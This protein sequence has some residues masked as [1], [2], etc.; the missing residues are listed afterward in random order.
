MGSD[1]FEAEASGS[2]GGFKQVTFCRIDAPPDGNR[3]AINDLGA[4]TNYAPVPLP[5]RRVWC[6]VSSPRIKMGVGDL[7]M[8]T[9]SST[10][11]PW[12]EPV[13]LG[14]RV[15]SAT[16]DAAPAFAENDTAIYFGSRRP[17]EDGQDDG[18]IDIWMVPVKRLK[19]H[20]G[21]K[22]KAENVPL[23]EGIGG[24]T[25]AWIAAAPWGATNN[26]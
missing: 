8:C 21:A 24:I 17:K 9:C 12:C 22:P 10:D 15:N 3:I 13:N 5:L 18:D 25:C 6:A 19:L 20:V 2:F 16:W 1:G 11:Q 14:P 4:K 26:G 23:P 7:W